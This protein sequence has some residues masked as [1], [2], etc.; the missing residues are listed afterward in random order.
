VLGAY[1]IQ[2]EGKRMSTME[3]DVGVSVSKQVARMAVLVALS[4]VGAFIK[5]PSPTGTVALD[6]APGY[7]G[8]LAF[9]SKEGALIAALGHLLSAGTVGFPLS[10]PLH[11]F[12]AAQMALFAAVFGYLQRRVGMGT[13]VVA[14]SLLN[15]VGA[16]AIFA[17]LPGFG[18]AFFGAM[19]LPLLVASTVNVVAAA[20]LFKALRKIF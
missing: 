1:F 18:P 7:L 19:L 4:G 5:I 16:P 11:L 6:S 3:K 13:A 12:V 20:L 9:G 17:L 2:Q 14:A 8:A 10:L 15:G